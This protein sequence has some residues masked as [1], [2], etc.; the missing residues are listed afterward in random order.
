MG[1]LLDAYALVAL[2]RD[3]RSAAT[4]EEALRRGS[5]AMSAINLAEAVEKMVRVERVDA[6]ALRTALEPLGMQVLPLSESVAWRAALLRARHYRRRTSE[7]SLADCCVVAHATPADAVMS[8]DAALL[9][10]AEAEGFRTV[11][12]A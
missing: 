11:R 1:T 6:E 10:M 4:V 7:V 8:G 2:L 9:R 5:A 12:L 3:E